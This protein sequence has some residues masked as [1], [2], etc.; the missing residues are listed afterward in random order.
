MADRRAGPSFS[1]A[2][3]LSG[4]VKKNEPTPAPERSA[5]VHRVDDRSV[6]RLVELSK[7]VPVIVEIIGGELEPSLTSIV[8][9][10]RGTLVLGIVKGEEAPELV[11]ALQVEGVPT[12]IALI[13]GQPVPLFKG[14]PAEPEVKQILDQVL[15]FAAENG[16]SGS[17]EVPTAAPEVEPEE[18]P[19]PPLHQEAF[20]ALSRN[21]L[22]GATSAYQKALAQNPS[23]SDATAGLAQVQLL[24][25]VRDYDPAQ[26]RQAAASSPEDLQAALAVAD[27]DVSG[28]HVEDAFG[29]LL[30]LYV[31]A[32]E[33]GRKALQE[34]LLHLFTVVGQGS[35]EVKKARS[36]LASLMF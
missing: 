13:A 17:V 32:D 35:P 5:L 15:K 2:V 6:G 29:R 27:L 22:E 8:E 34:R 28:G 21:D 4:L 10:Y 12:V 14:I 18:P 31:G 3:D 26:V 23:D 25:R 24:A 11:R 20:D 33:D 19:L 30:G 36:Q 16:V 9:S 1:G 7:S